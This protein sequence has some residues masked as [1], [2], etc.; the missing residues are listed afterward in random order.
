M[1]LQT[2]YKTTIDFKTTTRPT[3]IRLHRITTDTG[4]AVEFLQSYNQLMAYRDI[5]GKY[6]RTDKNTARPRT[7]PT[8]SRHIY[9]YLNRGGLNFVASTIVT[10]DII[11]DAF[12]YYINQ[13]TTD[14]V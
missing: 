3:N 12:T 7:S 5:N 8:S 6:Y 1:T 4:D 13:T 2:T 11:D 14:T 10:Q 9:S